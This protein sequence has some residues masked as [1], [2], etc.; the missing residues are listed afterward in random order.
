MKQV[1]NPFKYS[2]GTRVRD[3]ILLRMLEPQ[4]GDRI[5]DLGCGLGYF[6]DLL[7]GYG[8]SVTGVDIDSLCVNY[9]SK[10]MR[11]AYA[12]LDLTKVPYPYPDSYFNKALCSEVLE[13]I[14]DN[15]IVLREARRIL[16]PQGTLVVSTPCLEGIFGLFF[17]NI[18][19]D[20]VD[21]SSHEYHHHKGYTG[22][23]LGKLLTKHGFTILEIHY[24]MVA[25]IEIFMGLTK[26]LIRLLQLKKIN[27][28]ANALNVNSSLLWRVYKRLFPLV[29]LEARVEQP[30]SR[31]IKGHMIIMKAV[32]I[33]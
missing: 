19:H 23:T 6:A 26:I 3:S 2:I 30:L 5:L 18:G 15:D 24:T 11:G 32:K 13:H 25:G 20:S 21:S 22:E 10:Y 17:K 28:Q 1:E 12:E 9:C 7:V 29:L 4:S 27:S 31:F 33:C 16:R 8:A 14:K